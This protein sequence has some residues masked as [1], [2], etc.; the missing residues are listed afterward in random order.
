MVIAMDGERKEVVLRRV[1][2]P[3]VSAVT[4]ADE[5]DPALTESVYQGLDA[6]LDVYEHRPPHQPVDATFWR[7]V[8]TR[9]HAATIAPFWM[10]RTIYDGLND[11]AYHYDAA[12]WHEDADR[13]RRAAHV[14]AARGYARE[15][16]P[17]PF[18]GS[19]A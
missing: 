10:A 4:P 16:K 11:L 14:V 8:I 2:P 15:G 7:D 1:A 19:G 18:A 5:P 13:W 6:L 9:L 12:G 3:P 17:Y